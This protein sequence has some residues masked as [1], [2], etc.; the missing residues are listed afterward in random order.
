MHI[1]IMS[2]S[3]PL[4][5]SPMPSS[6]PSVSH[7]IIIFL[8]ME[9]HF[10]ETSA[11]VSSPDVYMFPSSN[12]RLAEELMAKTSMGE[13]TAIVNWREKRVWNDDVNNQ[14]T[15]ALSKCDENGMKSPFD[16]LPLFSIFRRTSLG[17]CSVVDF[18]NAIMCQI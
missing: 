12:C 6:K 17:C 2:F 13:G 15:F 5:L 18:T 9:R 11:V 7:S 8:H 16:A 10:Q 1:S 3:A 4:A 14:V